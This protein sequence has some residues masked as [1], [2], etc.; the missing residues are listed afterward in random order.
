MNLKVHS[1]KI[2]DQ[3]GEDRESTNSSAS[4]E[5]ISVTA[6]GSGY[7]ETPTVEID[8]P[9][10]AFGVQATA[11]ATLSS[12]ELSSVSIDNAGSGYTSTPLVRIIPGA[13]DTDGAGAA[14]Q[15]VVTD[16][17]S[18]LLPTGGNAEARYVTKKTTLQIPST[19]IRLLSTLS[20]VQGSYVDWYIRVSSTASSVNHD[21]LEWHRLSCDTERNQSK[22]YGEFLE[23]EF[24]L[25]DLPEFNVYDL[26]CVMGS[27]DPTRTPVIQSYRAILTA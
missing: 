5:S 9:D 27:N 24:Y 25:D 13:G 15:A 7:T 4:V 11:T 23:Y 19:G 26:K 20:S 18:E 21:E 14:A 2:N 6:S 12:G 17:N 1:H 22:T 8:P 10:L 3:P 16:F